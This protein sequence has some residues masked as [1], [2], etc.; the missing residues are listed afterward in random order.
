[1]GF[2]SWNCKACG[3][4]IRSPYEPEDT[5]W[6]SHAVALG[7][8]GTVV[9]GRYDGYGRLMTRFGEFDMAEGDDTP[10][11]YH[12]RCWKEAGQPKYSEPS[13]PADDQGYFIEEGEDDHV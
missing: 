3:K 4:S 9:H 11:M 6:M 10:C 13:A 7:K 12:E 1:M 8:D 5:E 2:F